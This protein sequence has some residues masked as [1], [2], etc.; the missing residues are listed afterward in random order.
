[1]TL[2]IRD[3][4]EKM[5]FNIVMGDITKMSAEAIVN[6]ANENLVWGG[7]VCGAIYEAA[8]GKELQKECEK[9][10]R[11][12]TGK[13]V[14]TKGCRL[15]AKYIIHAVGPMWHG[16]N[17]G[18]KELLQSCY[19][20][21]LALAKKY[22]IKSI[23]FPLI[24]SGIYGYPKEEALDVAVDCAKEFL[25]DNEMDIYLVIFDHKSFR[26]NDKLFEALKSYID[27]Y[28]STETAPRDGE[29]QR[30]FGEAV[31]KMADERGLTAEKVC[32]RANIDMSLYRE[33][34]GGKD[35]IIEKQ[36]VLALAV[37]F[38]LSFEDTERFLAYAGY[39]LSQAC[40]TDILTAYF[41]SKK[42]YDIYEVNKVLFAFKQ[43]ILGL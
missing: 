37:A 13:A 34:V 1:M 29:E 17:N 12:E 4:E 28:L 43:G 25:K 33:I 23:A 10:G 15:P 38:E 16:G 41:I 11:C 6:A 2:K 36:T 5:P 31:K 18:E 8:G 14:I 3:K 26:I 42:I 7:G 35:C 9:I 30:H 24:S 40:K 32:Y 22:E 19:R 27:E 21:A 39:D 20:E